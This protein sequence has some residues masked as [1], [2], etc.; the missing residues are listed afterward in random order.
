MP[1]QLHADNMHLIFRFAHQHLFATFQD[2]LEAVG[3]EGHPGVLMR[4]G[5]R[6]VC[7][8]GGPDGRWKNGQFFMWELVLFATL[9]APSAGK[10]SLNG[11]ELTARRRARVI[12]AM[13]DAPQEEVAS[14]VTLVKMSS[15]DERG[16]IGVAEEWIFATLGRELPSHPGPKPRYP[17]RR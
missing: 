3:V 12:L 5:D 10:R 16:A 4:E 11:R 7:S 1:E 2:A 6:Y 9:T 14:L 8:R 17:V 15:E 13:Q